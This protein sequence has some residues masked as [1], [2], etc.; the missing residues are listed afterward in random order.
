MIDIGL[1]RRSNT[2]KYGELMMS[3]RDQFAFNIDVYS[4]TLNSIYELIENHSGNKEGNDRS[5]HNGDKDRDRNCGGRGRGYKGD[6]KTD[7]I[8]SQASSMLKRAR[9]YQV[10]TTRQSHELPALG[11]IKRD[12]LPPYVR[13]LK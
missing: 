4:K 5:N 7:E 8:T 11:V 12:I 9:S 2:K 10:L 13:T 3:I 1:L 6:E